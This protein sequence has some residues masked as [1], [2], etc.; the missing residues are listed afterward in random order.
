MHQP[1]LSSFEVGGIA[2]QQPTR[3]PG[4]LR[5]FVCFLSCWFRAKLYPVS[6]HVEVTLVVD[7][8]P[9]ID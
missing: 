6:N 7:L 2:S 1:A 5:L 8:D 4:D 9:A 3:T